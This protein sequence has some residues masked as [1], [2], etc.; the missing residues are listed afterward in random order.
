ML[1]MLARSCLHCLSKRSKT[2]PRKS[3]NERQTI[4]E[5]RFKVP[6]TTISRSK[7][8][9]RGKRRKGAMMQSLL[10]RVYRLSSKLKEDQRTS[11]YG[12]TLK[13]AVRLRTVQGSICAASFLLDKKV[14][15]ARITLYVLMQKE[16]A[17]F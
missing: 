3:W 17:A 11:V 5:S 10:S 13:K 16:I 1:S 14:F 7:D 12:I 9:I 2:V 15:V 4:T 6:Q 8:R